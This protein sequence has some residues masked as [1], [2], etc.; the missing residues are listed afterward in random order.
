MESTQFNSRLQP[1]QIALGMTPCST[2]LL[3]LDYTYGTTANN[4][5]VLSQRITVPT[6]G[7][8]AGFISVQSYDYD[9]LNRLKQAEEKPQG[10]TDTNCTSDPTKCWKQTF[11]FDRFGNRRLDEANTTMPSSFA[12]PALTNPTVSTSNTACRPPAGRTT[13]GRC[14]ETDRQQLN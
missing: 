9:S 4:G 1:T 2:N 11:T 3:D 10:W 6:V 8:M 5:N 12:N 7:A 14:G 13:Q